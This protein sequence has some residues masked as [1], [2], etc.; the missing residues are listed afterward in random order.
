MS[1]GI[2]LPQIRGVDVER[3]GLETYKVLFLRILSS[4][5]CPVEGCTARANTRGRLRDHFMYR[6]WKSKVDTMQEGPKPLLRCDKFGMRMPEDKIFKHR[7]T[8]KC[9]KETERLF[10]RRDVEM[11]VRCG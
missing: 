11:S 6:H 1:H 10:R 9:N 7:N 3:G 2:L 4:V 5:G 8:D